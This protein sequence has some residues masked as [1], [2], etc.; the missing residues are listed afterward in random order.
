MQYASRLS[1]CSASHR[2]LV[3][4]PVLVAMVKSY[5]PGSVRISTKAPPAW[6]VYPGSDMANRDDRGYH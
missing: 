2:A 3:T 4:D 5:G 1:W 6:L